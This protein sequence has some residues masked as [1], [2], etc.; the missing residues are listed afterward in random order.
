MKTLFLTLII[1]GGLLGTLP[2]AAQVPQALNY[3]GRVAV[4]G[5]AFTGTGQF[6]FA[7]VDGAGTVLWSSHASAFTSAPVSAGL[8]TVRLGD[9]SLTNMAAVPSTLFTNSDLRLRVWFNDGVNGVQQLTPDQRLAPV[10]YAHRAA[11]VDSVPPG[12]IA[13]NSIQ[14]SQLAHSS[15]KGFDQGIYEVPPSGG[16]V[17]I[18][19]S[20]P[21]ESAPVVTFNGQP[22]PAADVTTTGFTITVP[23]HNLVVD[24]GSPVSNNVGKWMDM[25]LVGGNPA[26]AYTDDTTGDLKYVRALNAAGSAWSAPVTVVDGGVA[27]VGAWC[28]LAVVSNNPAIAYYDETNRDLKYVRASNATGS[29]WSAPVTVAAHATNDLGQGCRLK[30]FTVTVGSERP[31]IAYLDATAGTVRVTVSTNTTGTA[32][33]GPLTPDATVSGFTDPSSMDMDTTPGGLPVIVYYHP[34]TDRMR[35]VKST[36]ILGGGWETPD[37][38]GP[39]KVT[40]VDIFTAGGELAVKYSDP[41]GVYSGYSVETR[42]LGRDIICGPVPSSRIV[43]GTFPLAVFEY[44]IGTQ[45]AWSEAGAELGYS[46]SPPSPFE[47]LQVYSSNSLSAVRLADG[48]VLAACRSAANNGQLSVSNVNAQNDGSWTAGVPSPVVATA[49][50]PFAIT[51]EDLPNDLFGTQNHSSGPFSFAIGRYCGALGEYSTALGLSC[52]AGDFSV[53]AG[54]GN[55]AG[56]NCTSIGTSNSALGD[57]STALGSQNQ[58][59][60]RFSTVMGYN[61]AARGDY[62]FAAGYQAKAETAGEISLGLYPTSNTGSATA[63]VTTERLFEI[64]NGSVTGSTT[65]NALT[66]LKDGRMG[67]GTIDSDPEITHRLTLPNSATPANGQARANAWTTYSDSRIKTEQRPLAY[68]LKEIMKLQPRAYTQHSGCVEHG[69]FKCEDA[70]DGSAATIGFI[71]QEVES[72]IPEAVQKPEDTENQL[73]GMSYEKLIPVLVKATQELKTENDALKTQLSTMQQRLEKLERQ[74]RKR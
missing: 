15:Q 26:I 50:A 62:S 72:V 10:G 5:T 7:L 38:I 52:I 43:E 14:P 35:L 1:A 40:R 19:F 8:Y 3:Q 64:G 66:I 9:T 53:A 48:T 11:S 30:T 16:T 25:T 34:G 6:R 58:A 2:V 68:G 65:S 42:N 27:V 13:P 37:D 44:T 74:P 22:V 29:A 31:V 28:S 47:T 32:W 12:A 24:D 69:T 36:G 18:P 41:S 71:A 51:M 4:N 33:G 59:L 54:S 21:F 39:G 46:W 73:Y 17:T 61:A 60:G 55:V 67:L 56:S 49:L 63:W 57:H 45:L 20:Q 70:K 23:V